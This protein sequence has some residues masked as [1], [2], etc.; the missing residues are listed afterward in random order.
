MKQVLVFVA[1]AVLAAGTVYVAMRP[2]EQPVAK[3]EA[4]SPVPAEQPIAAPTPTDQPRV[5]VTPEVVEPVV[6]PVPSRIAP[7]DRKPSPVPRQTARNQ[8]ARPSSPT[9]VADNK[10]AVDPSSQIQP[11]P[12]PSIPATTNPSPDLARV[13]IPDPP[14]PEPKTVTIPAGTLLTVRVDELLTTQRNQSGDSFRASLD[15]PLVVDGF[16]IAERGARVEGRI[17]EADPGGKVKGLSRISLELVRLNTADGQRLR[18]Q[19]ESFAK[20]AE[21]SKSKDAAKIGVAAGIGAAIGAIAGGGKGA[22]IGAGVGGAAGAGG[23]MATRGGAAEIPAETR[24]SFRLRDA[25]T[26]TEKL[27]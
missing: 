2:G 18:L 10:P 11:G 17:I 25:V 1:G 21:Q 26:V 20:Q 16:V 15:Q 3:T 23:V 27:N 7:R 22:A 24:V 5:P 8:P 4:P 14:K 19:T 6:A 12:V 13:V 9:P